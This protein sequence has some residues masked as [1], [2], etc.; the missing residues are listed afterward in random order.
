MQ[1]MAD[2]AGTKLRELGTN[3]D[4]EFKKT[5]FI[6]E[7]DRTKLASDAKDKFSEQEGGPYTPG[8][9]CEREV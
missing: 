6:V 8:S 5:K 7:R 2:A 1:S 9:E 3:L 4:Q